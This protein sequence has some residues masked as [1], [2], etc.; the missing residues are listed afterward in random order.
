MEFAAAPYE[1]WA[2][3]AKRTHDVER[4]DD[5]TKRVRR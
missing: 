3:L 5:D 4:A 1:R 2:E